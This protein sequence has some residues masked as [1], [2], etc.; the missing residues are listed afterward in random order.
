MTRW[1]TF[2]VFFNPAELIIIGDA[3][4]INGWTGRTNLGNKCLLSAVDPSPVSSTSSQL[5]T[6][7]IYSKAPLGVTERKVMAEQSLFTNATFFFFLVILTLFHSFSKPCCLRK[8]SHYAALG[9]LSLRIMVQRPRTWRDSEWAPEV[10]NLQ[11]CPG[12]AG[13]GAS[14]G[15]RGNS[16]GQ[17]WGGG[18]LSSPGAAQGS[19]APASAAM[20][21]L[22]T[23]C[24]AHMEQAGAPTPPHSPE[25][26]RVT[27][28]GGTAQS[29]A[30]KGAHRD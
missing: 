25:G 7:C 8:F 19:L 9:A 29:P 6:P 14:E 2:C 16:P 3:R 5:S 28:S 17:S 20:D 23:L 18:A 1:I 21:E 22:W 11:L 13:P 24:C 15:G 10:H 27:T 12:K 26:R 30:G 4:V